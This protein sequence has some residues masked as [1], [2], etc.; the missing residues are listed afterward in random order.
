VDALSLEPV[1]MGQLAHGDQ[2][3]A[4]IRQ[5]ESR[6]R[7]GSASGQKET[8]AIRTKIHAGAIF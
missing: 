2:A 5:K 4:G 7:V 1:E 6:W 8:A 3:L